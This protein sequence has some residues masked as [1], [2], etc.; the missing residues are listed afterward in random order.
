[1]MSSLSRRQFLA[2]IAGLFIAIGFAIYGYS[3]AVNQFVEFDDTLLIID[4]LSVL[5]AGRLSSVLWAF[6]HYDPE[7]YIPLT[8]LSFQLDAV[9][10]GLNPVIF[11]LDN[12]LEHIANALLCTWI[13]QMLFR[14][15]DVSILLGLL[16]LVH[17]LNT[18][19]VA[20][21]SGR[22]DLLSTLFFLA[23]VG[24]Y[25]RFRDA[26]T[27][28]LR[29]S[30]LV[31]FVL[32][33]LAK[34]SVAPLPVVLLVFDWLQDRPMNGKA[35]WSKKGFFIAAFL[36]GLIAILG[37]DEVLARTSTESVVLLIP[38]TTVF[39]VQKLFVPLNLSI[40]YPFPQDAVTLATPSLLASLL[41][42][43]ATLGFLV[44]KRNRY[45][46]VVAGCAIAFL[47]LVPSFFQYYRGS[48]LYLATDRYMY[49]PFIGVL[50]MLAPALA[51]ALSRWNRV[52]VGVSICILSACGV[53]SFQRSL[54]W[55]NT[56]TLFSD[57]L[58]T[59]DTFGAYEKIGAWQ[60][61]QG[62][63]AEAIEALK[64]SIELAPSS[65][66]YFRLGV[67]AMEE[68]NTADAK[69]FTQEALKL[70]PE[71]PQAHVNMSTFYWEE[72]NTAKAIEHAE[73]AV[74][75]HPWQEMGLGNLA[76]MY[77]LTGRKDDALRIINQLLDVYPE[78]TRAG[79]LL[80]R[81]ESM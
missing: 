26:P 37:K 12:L 61:R 71:N 33:L 8:F 39:Y 57:S 70:S 35:L 49:A 38:R 60:L 42:C 10:G 63:R 43:M 62:R 75:Y 69:L 50:I 52:T 81:L 40:L 66:A 22:K 34:V 56:Y 31:L 19:A 27:I 53:L 4:N 51:H 74:Q 14:R 24:T 64:K 5:Q 9:I 2:A 54:V 13:L 32:G 80:K 44:W 29:S 47:M 1:M 55:E 25:I 28:L 18:E 46:A 77:T 79:P 65:A 76:T 11:H 45:P 48:E 36:L 30:S 41:A 7:L 68:G 20:W 3:V 72:G 23:S 58:K 15:L 21:A 67:A 6:G 78:S 17:P 59:A 73:L 16:F